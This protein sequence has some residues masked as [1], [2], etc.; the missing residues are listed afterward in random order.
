MSLQLAEQYEENEQYDKAYE[1]YKRLHAKNPD[2]LSLLERLGHTAMVLDKKDEAAEYYSKIIEKDMTNT[3]AYEQLMDIYVTTD[4]YKYYVSR[5][6]LHSVEH[7]L[8]HAINDYK[9]ALSHAEDEKQMMTTR[10]VLANLYEQ[11]GRNMK[12][13]DEYL[14]I[15]DHGDVPVEVYL[16]LANLYVKEDAISS[17]IDMLV[18]AKKHYDI[19]AVKETLAQLYLKNNQPEKALEV[20]DDDLMKIKCLLET[21]E[22]DKAYE[23]IQK[24]ENQ[25]KNN[26]QFYSVKAQ[27]YFITGDYDKALEC[28]NQYDNLEKNSPLT[29]QMRA[30]IYENKN[31]D[32]NAH[33]NWGKYN[34]V[35]KNKDIA[36]NEYLNAHQ[37]NEK[38]ADLVSTIAMLLEETGDKLHAVEFYEKLSKLEPNNRKALEK[39][40]DFRESLGDYRMQAEYLEQ[41]YALDKRNAGVIKKLAIAYEKI[42]NKPATIEFYTKYLELSKGA[43]DYEQVKAK[44]A[45]LENTAMEEDEGLIDKILRMFNKQ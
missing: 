8:E 2:D 33:L 13:V 1:E 6:N 43:S 7:Q 29:Y 40:A 22:K 19:P 4:K 38:D 11:T 26:A 39:L 32:F 14:K 3:L 20:T 10:F 30:L 24:V 42:K 9:K 44:L 12:A 36:I 37:L 17:A 5:G 15:V 27:Y 16:K 21:G 34:L 45:K 23:S 18:N 31:D 35:R 41:L 28:V 25:Y